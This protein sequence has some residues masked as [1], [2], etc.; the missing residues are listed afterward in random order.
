M[1][2]K[3]NDLRAANQLLIDSL[4]KAEAVH[5][6]VYIN[7]KEVSPTLSNVIS[8]RINK[9]EVDE[10]QMANL[11]YIAETMKNDTTLNIVLKG[12]A[13][14]NTGTASY[15]KS[16]SVKRAE[17]VKDVLVNTFGIDDS[18]IETEGLGDTEQPYTENNWNRV[19]LFFKKR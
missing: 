18:R 3:I 2:R 14:K 8:F 7:V 5:D 17:A 4:A 11:S 16:L 6:T 9:Y 1:N 19:V 13:D 10:V 15:N 12:Y